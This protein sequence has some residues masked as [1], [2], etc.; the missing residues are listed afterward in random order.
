[1]YEYF[2]YMDVSAPHSFSVPKC[3]IFPWDW[4][5]VS[6]LLWKMGIN[7]DPTTRVTNGF[8]L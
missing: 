6:H 7:F 3:V 8:Y 4:R 2:Y 5:V 1:M